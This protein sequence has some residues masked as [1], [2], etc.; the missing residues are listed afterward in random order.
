MHVAH[1]GEG[2]FMNEI[3]KS[4]NLLPYHDVLTGDT[5]RILNW[6]L[7]LFDFEESGKQ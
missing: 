2:H 5:T 7:E 3:K 6:D 1:P 4:V